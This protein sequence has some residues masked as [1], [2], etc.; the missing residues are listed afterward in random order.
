MNIKENLFWAFFYNAICIP[1]AAG[2]F[3]FVWGWAMNP[4]IGA[5]AMALS[6]VC[7]VLN[8]LR[9]N[10]FKVY[11]KKH[12]HPLRTK[13]K[14]E[15]NMEKVFNVEGMMCE[16]CE[17]HVKEALEKIKGVESVTADRNANKVVIVLSKEVKDTKLIKAIEGAGYKVAGE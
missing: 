11:N 6:S 4:M 14:G 7:V 15:S 2:A 16:R 3:Y 13:T 8:A 10:L 5:A 9:L 17:A 1:I 12:D